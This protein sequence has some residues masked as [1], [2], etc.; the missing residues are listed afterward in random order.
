MSNRKLPGGPGIQRT[1]LAG[2]GSR[3]ARVAS[4]R[5]PNMCRLSSP[6]IASNESGAS[7]RDDRPLSVAASVCLGPRVG[8]QDASV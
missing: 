7:T 3:S 6:H 5:R 1:Q 4:H 8:M 2:L